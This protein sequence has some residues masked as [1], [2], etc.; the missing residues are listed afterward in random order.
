MESGAE[1]LKPSVYFRIALSVAILCGVFWAG[2]QTG[3]YRLAL[4]DAGFAIVTSC[5]FAVLLRTRLSF[6]EVAGVLAI[7]LL[8]FYVDTRILGY[9]SSWQSEI[10]LLGVAGL[11][12]LALRVIWSEGEERRMAVFTLMPMLALHSAGWCMPLFHGWT[13]K[14]QPAVLDLYLYSFDASLGVQ[15]SFL[16][17][18]LFVRYYPLFIVCLVVYMIPG[19]ALALS[20]AGCLMKD[21]KT[22]L[23]AFI[24]FFI[25]APAGF[26]LYNFF[27]ALG[28]IYTFKGIFPWHALTFAQARHLVVKP[29]VLEGLRNAMPSLH[30]GWAY[31]IFWYSRRLSLLE[32]VAAG[33]ILVFTLLATLGTGEHYFIDL[34]VAVPFTLMILAATNMIVHRAVAPLRM[35]LFI[36]LALTLAWFAALRFGLR[37]FWISPA[38]PW[39]ACLL[40]IAACFWMGRGL[41]D[42]QARGTIET[43]WWRKQNGQTKVLTDQQ[44]AMVAG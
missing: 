43:S 13:S 15:P 35:P 12:V 38:I 16:I 9:V 17:G 40:T 33:A 26:V 32:R 4:T 11:G 18:Q 34:V 1:K 7:A 6:R 27:P 30:A 37:V 19:I 29:I 14:A 31:L 39:A 8:L 25:A 20:Y 2:A 42:E 5:F 24:A 22:A 28:P 23:S 10:F 3:F 41:S 21:K 36:G 44:D